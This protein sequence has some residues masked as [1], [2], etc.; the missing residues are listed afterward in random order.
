MS[1]FISLLVLFMLGAASLAGAAEFLPLISHGTGYITD[2][3]QSGTLVAVANGEGV[4]LFDSTASGFVPLS[5]LDFDSR[6]DQV[7]ISGNSLYI[8]VAWDGLHAVD[9]SDPAAPVMGGHVPTTG[10][11]Q[12]LEVTGDVI[13][14]LRV[15]VGRSADL[16]R[17]RPLQRPPHEPVSD[18]QPTL[19]RCHRQRRSALGDGL[20]YRRLLAR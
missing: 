4:D 11:W 6:V 17:S 15:P 19:D 12:E 14:L 7:V 2:I 8:G 20:R 9:I 10:E 5:H 18:R 3:D 1:R 13:L 16:V